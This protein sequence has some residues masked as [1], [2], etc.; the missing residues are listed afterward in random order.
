MGDSKS[1]YAGDALGFTLVLACVRAWDPSSSPPFYSLWLGMSRCV[2]VGILC[3]L[4]SVTV[5][6]NRSG[7]CWERRGIL[8]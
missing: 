4:G 7:V 2:G 3:T 8:W 5:R 1:K 6:A